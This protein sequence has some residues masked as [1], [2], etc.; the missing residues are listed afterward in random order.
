MIVRWSFLRRVARRDRL[1][2]VEQGSGLLVKCGFENGGAQL[3][4]IVR[5]ALYPVG[6]DQAFAP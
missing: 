3:I 2:D 4:E 1:S 6:L 5:K